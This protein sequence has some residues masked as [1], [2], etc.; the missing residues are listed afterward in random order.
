MANLYWKRGVVASKGQGAILWDVNGRE[1]IDCTSNYGVAI[2]GH[3]HPKVVEAVKLQ[4]E[5]LMSCHGGYNNEARSE[6]LEKINKIAPKELTRTY[7]S[8]SGTE[9]VEFAL[10]LAKKKTEKT[11]IIAMM[12]AFHGKS[13]GALSA[14]WK[15]KY[16]EGF[17]PMVPGYKHAPYG[18][19]EKIRDTITTDT[20]AIITEPIQGEG[21]INLPPQD[22]LQQL[23]ELCDEK[24]ILL[25]FDEIQTGMGRTGKMFACQ[26]TNVTPDIMCLS[27]GIASGLPLGATM[28][29][30]EIMS[31]IGIGDHSSTF[32]GGPIQCAAGAATIDV[33]INEKLPEKAA[34]NG[35]YI[36][37]KMNEMGRK[38][39][40]IREARGLGL[41]LGVETRFEIIN[42]MNRCQEKNVLTLEAGRNIL[43]LLPPLVITQ[44]QIDKVLT[45]LNEVFGVEESERFPH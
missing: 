38:Y 16:K 27:K 6:F 25:I 10:K 30:E 20:A 35:K 21:G 32:G 12:N 4:A 44:T 2:V 41:M 13:L 37:N 8:N 31:S 17:G 15:K 5:Q 19:I 34:S 36:L 18:N 43:R 9:A 26:H 29:K 28:A 22:F 42:I 23:R 39:K 7:L 1:Y 14:T 11:E 33:L 45:T 24:N 40:T 3:C